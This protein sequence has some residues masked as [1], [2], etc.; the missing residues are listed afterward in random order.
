MSEVARTLMERVALLERR[1]AQ[2]EA[3]VLPR[4]REFY[5][6]DEEIAASERRLVLT[7]KGEPTHE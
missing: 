1:L 3:R 6:T 2:L 7:P 4:P 5:W